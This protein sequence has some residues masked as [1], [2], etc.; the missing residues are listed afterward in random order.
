MRRAAR[1][2]ARAG[3][4]GAGRQASRC[5]QR[6][7]HAQ[8]S[9]SSTPGPGRCAAAAHTL[10]LRLSRA[11]T[12]CAALLLGMAAGVGVPMSSPPSSSTSTRTL[13]ALRLP[14]LAA[15]RD[16]CCVWA[17]QRR[18]GV[19]CWGWGG[20][21][22]RPGG[23]SCPAAGRGSGQAAAAAAAQLVKQ[24][25]HCQPRAPIA[26]SSPPGCDF[27]SSAAFCSACAQQHSRRGTAASA[28]A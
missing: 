8:G 12:C 22:G 11:Y 10:R 23:V 16:A 28:G 4:C 7:Q 2:L 26:S 17:W 27:M 1:R 19:R 25:Q 14:R 18:P 9:S 20:G 21:A 24:R 13:A 5:A 3:A 6:A 15:R